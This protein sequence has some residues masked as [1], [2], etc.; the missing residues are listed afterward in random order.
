MDLTKKQTQKLVKA[1]IQNDRGAQEVLYKL[2]YADMM[3]VCGSYLADEELAREA[4]T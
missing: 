4:L 2:Y 3:R 1:S